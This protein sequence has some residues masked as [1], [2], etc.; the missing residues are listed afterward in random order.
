[1]SKPQKGQKAP[2]RKESSSDSIRRVETRQRRRNILIASIVIIL[3]VAV[4][5]LAAIFIRGPLGVGSTPPAFSLQQ[6]SAIGYT[7]NTT[8]LSH[9]QGRVILLEFMVSWCPFCQQTAP[10]LEQ[11]YENYTAK[12]VIFLAV[13][14]LWTGSSSEGTATLA[15]TQQFIQTYGSQYPYLLDSTGGVARSFGVDSTPTFFIIN[16]SYTISSI[17][18]GK[19][20]TTSLS[21]AIWTAL[22]Q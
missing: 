6:V 10:A 2:S 15:T 13:A 8:T 12:G 11:V 14:E 5:V 7:G 17:L 18:N 19:Q 22:K 16:K 20:D 1:M 21:N 9:A 3:I 4:G